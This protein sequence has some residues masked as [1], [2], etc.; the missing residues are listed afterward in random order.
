MHKEVHVVRT[1]LARIVHDGG[2]RE[3]A[4]A[5]M[6]RLFEKDREMK[7]AWRKFARN[8]MTKD[9]K[10]DKMDPAGKL[11]AF[12]ADV[13]MQEFC[14]DLSQAYNLF[15]PP[16]PKPIDMLHVGMVELIDRQERPML[17]FEC[18]IQGKYKKWN[19][20]AGWLDSRSRHTPQAF[21]FFTYRYTNGEYIVVDIQGVG[22]IYT[23]P[24]VHCSKED[25][26]PKCASDGSETDE[27]EEEVHQFGEGNLGT[28]GM[29]LFVGTFRCTSVLFPLICFITSIF[30]LNPPV[31]HELSSCAKIEINR[32]PCL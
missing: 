31:H 27:E 7:L 26:A 8:V 19:T 9:Y 20:N 14:K 2:K 25:N 16:P 23:D 4:V 21:S 17:A 13:V 24:Q 3:R 32:F 30:L 1:E 6:D 18:F 15:D 5:M 29:A 10:P 12:K 11:A 28:R 22:N